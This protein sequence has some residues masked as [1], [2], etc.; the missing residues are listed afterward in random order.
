MIESGAKVLVGTALYVV[1]MWVAGRNPRAAGMMLTFPTLNGIGLLLADPAL[2]ESASHSMMLMP[3]LNGIFCASYLAICSHLL[4]RG[5][6]AGRTSAGLLLAMSGIWI[7]VTAGIAMG[8]WGISAPLQ[9]GYG[10]AVLGAGLV[11]TW[12]LPATGTPD[13]KTGT[14]I[15][16]PDVIARNTWRIVL[17][18]LSLGLVAAFERMGGSGSVL[19]I[20]ASLPLVAFF[21]LHSLVSDERNSLSARMA[22]LGG[23]AHGVWLGPA[24]A[25][26]FVAAYWRG[27]WSLA[28]WANGPAYLAGGTAGLIVGWT[29]AFAVI[30]FAAA[31][32]HRA[33]R[34]T[35]AA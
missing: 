34:S 4:R 10:L 12:L 18:A 26:F 23:L 3:V 5:W 16:F 29:S 8:A 6:D 14:A 21:G 2:L 7:A 28:L 17:F 30:W 1:V 13:Q 24:I 15:R 20:L 27:L 11:L 31:L 32:I 35:F 9:W 19:G 25:I 22:T 33:R